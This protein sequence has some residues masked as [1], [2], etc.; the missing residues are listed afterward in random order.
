MESDNVESKTDGNT[1]VAK[2]TAYLLNFDDSKDMTIFS[3]DIA[4]DGKYA[5]FTEHMPF[6]FEADEHFFKDA[7]RDDVEPI[8]QEPESGHGDHGE[9]G[10]AFEWAG[11]FDV[12]AGTYT[13][14]FAKVDG[15]YADPAMK[16]IILESDDIESSEE[17]AESL[18]ESDNVESKTDGNTLVA[19]E[20]AY[21]L[22]F[23]DSKDMTIFS[24]DIAKDGKYAFFTEH[25]PFEFEAD[26]H[27]FKDAS[28]DDVE[29][30]MEEPESGHGHHHHHHHAS[31]FDPHIWLDPVLVKQQVNNIR[32]GLIEAD[33][34]N[35][36]QYE[37]NAIAYNEKLDELT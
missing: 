13:W 18:L 34:Q 6:E 10:H 30:I 25:M 5:F 22:N 33:P 27:F 1:L 9:E 15:D 2:E 14:S 20:V 16:M 19:K 29:P 12:A 17:L 3:V 31:E 21:L 7:S 8:M 37:A 36:E 23:D 4:Q 11:V 35:R 26:E 24:V 28:R 32:D